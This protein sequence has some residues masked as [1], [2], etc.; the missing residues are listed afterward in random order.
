MKR[1]LMVLALSA[2]KQDIG[3]TSDDERIGQG[4]L[5]AARKLSARLGYQDL[6]ETRQ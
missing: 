2:V 4:L 3:D 1:G 6:Q 5:A